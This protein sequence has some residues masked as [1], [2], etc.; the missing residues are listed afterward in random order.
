MGICKEK[1]LLNFRD[2][3]IREIMQTIE[4]DAELL[5][6]HNLMDYSLLFAIEKNEAF[7]RL[8]GGSKVSKSTFSGGMCDEETDKIL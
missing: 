1:I 7:M 3:D 5:R 4:H 6:A 2:A 8:K